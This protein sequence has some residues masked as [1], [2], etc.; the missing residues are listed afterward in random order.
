MYSLRVKTAV[1]FISDQRSLGSNERPATVM[2]G[3]FADRRATVVGSLPARFCSLMPP[4]P[5]LVAM[6]VFRLGE[7][8]N[9]APS[10]PPT[11][12]QS[13]S[14]PTGTMKGSM[15]RR[16]GYETTQTRT[17]EGVGTRRVRPR[18]ASIDSPHLEMSRW[19]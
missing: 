4:S 19:M 8:T 5:G 16:T 18:P 10:R 13:S 6:N 11:R 17:G 7:G 9:A 12:R 15:P 2:M 14:T 1:T 3:R